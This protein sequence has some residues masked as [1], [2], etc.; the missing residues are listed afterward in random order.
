MALGPAGFFMNRVQQC[1]GAGSGMANGFGQL[2]RFGFDQPVIAV[3]GDSTFFHAVIPALINGVHNNSEFVLV[4][5]DNRATAMTGFQPNPGTEYTAMGEPAR[6]ISIEKICQA[7]GARVEVCDPFNLSATQSTLLDLLENE[8][9]TRVV[10]MRR[11]CELVRGKREKKPYVVKVDQS[12][13]LAD[14]CGCNRLCTGVFGCPALGLDKATG[15]TKVDEVLC[16]G[17]GVCADICPQ[18]AI[19]REANA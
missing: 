13:C 18:G 1:M 12:K 3:C 8:K 6:M 16:N 4:V 9:G 11:Q 2:W 10:V 7:I 14:A 17:C 5:L 19:I 15:K